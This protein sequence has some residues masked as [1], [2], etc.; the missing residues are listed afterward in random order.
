MGTN[1]SATKGDDSKLTG[2]ATS[3]ITLQRIGTGRR[4]HID[5]PR[6]T[7]RSRG[8]E[9]GFPL[10]TWNIGGSARRKKHPDDGLVTD[11]GATAHRMGEHGF[12]ERTCTE[13]GIGALI[14]GAPDSARIV[15]RNC[16][17]KR[18][19]RLRR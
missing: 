3:Q 18:N 12:V 4:K 9:R 19:I 1:L 6:I 17:D 14:E 15:G 8:V 7:R 13:I 5:H 2:G 16:L 10:T 11:I